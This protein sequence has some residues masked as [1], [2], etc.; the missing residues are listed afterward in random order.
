MIF[1]N[2]ID[3]KRYLNT[4]PFFQGAVDPLEMEAGWLSRW[5]FFSLKVG[6]S[7]ENEVIF[8]SLL[9]DEIESK[10]FVHRHKTYQSH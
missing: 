9:K 5:L 10:Q 4:P 8:C 6:F 2:N 7:Q 1:S 3:E